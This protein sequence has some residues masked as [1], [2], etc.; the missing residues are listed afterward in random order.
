MS[1]KLWDEYTSYVNAFYAV[2]EH[3]EE[4]RRGGGEVGAGLT[5]F[6]HDANPFLWD[7]HSSADPSVHDNFSATFSARFG[8]NMSSTQDALKFCRDWLDQFG[9]K[10]YNGELLD[11][12]DSVVDSPQTW[13][14]A[15]A[16]IKDQID[17]RDRMTEWSPQDQPGQAA[18]HAEQNDAAA[19]TPLVQ[20][21]AEA[22]APEPKHA[23]VEAV[24]PAIE[25]PTPT[26]NSREAQEPASEAEPAVQSAP[27]PY[28]RNTQKVA[29]TP[30]SELTN[31]EAATQPTPAVVYVPVRVPVSEAAEVVSGPTQAAP[32]STPQILD[33]D[34]VAP[35]TPPEVSKATLSDTDAIASLLAMDD[36]LLARTLEEFFMRGMQCGT[37]VEL[38]VRL[39]GNVVAC[40]G[41]TFVELMPTPQNPSGVSAVVSGL[42]A[43]YGYSNYL[44]LLL[45]AIEQKTL[46]RGV[47]EIM[48]L[49]SS[50]RTVEACERYGFRLEG[51]RLLLHL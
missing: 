50:A 40:A 9:A 42:A 8:S 19:E 32:D 21:S 4:L 30:Q 26:D 24:V 25:V 28:H 6:C 35:G 16:P 38:V 23:R 43:R 7:S 34:E 29:P 15:Y 20:A 2:Q 1:A 31:Q 46:A 10:R 41:L 27:L 33:D 5:A 3:F 39:K 49:D 37:V 13:E 14:S 22:Q 45:K 51:S 44:Q 18:A 47:G 12:F 48:V 36:P 17:L 11:A